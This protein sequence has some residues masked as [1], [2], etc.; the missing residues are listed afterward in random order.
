ML[1]IRSIEIFVDRILDN[2]EIK[3][4]GSLNDENDHDDDHALLPS[5]KEQLRVLALSVQVLEC[6]NVLSA[7]ESRLLL[8]CERRLR[9]KQAVSIAQRDMRALFK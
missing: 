7:D 2:P 6:R 9:S 1:E 5:L 8:F 3:E 4:N